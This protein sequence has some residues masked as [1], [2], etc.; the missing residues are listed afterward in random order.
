MKKVFLLLVLTL[1]SMVAKA[2]PVIPSRWDRYLGMT[3]AMTQVPVPTA[4]IKHIFVS[5]QKHLARWNVQYR[6]S[7]GARRLWQ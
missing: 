4:T 6:A 1:L 7:A 5:P 2:N 3:A